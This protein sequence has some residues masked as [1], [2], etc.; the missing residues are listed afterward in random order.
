MA[1]RFLDKATKEYHRRKARLEM[2]GWVLGFI[3]VVI[4]I[5]GIWSK[6]MA[7]SVI[8]ILFLALA[9]YFIIM[10]RMAHKTVFKK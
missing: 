5:A 8:G 6:I 3:G 4:L 1:K 10:G 7:L 9:V 2:P